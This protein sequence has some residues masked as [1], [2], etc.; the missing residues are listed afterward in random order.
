V[1]TFAI[2]NQKGGAG[3]STMTANLAAA[4]GRQGRRV[5]AVDVDPQ[6]N[7][8]EMLG[9]SPAEADYTLAEL[10]AQDELELEGAV[11]AA[12]LPG[13]DLLL[14]SPLLANVEASLAL[15]KVAPAKY[16][17]KRLT[18]LLEAAAYDVV[19]FDSPP[20]L[21][22][23]TINVLCLA[24]EVVIPIAMS[25]RNAW[26]GAADLVKTIEECREE[27]PELEIR[28]AVRSRSQKS[29]LLY[30]ALEP[31]LARL[32][33]PVL[34]A[35]IPERVAFQNSGAE[36]VPLVAQRPGSP[37]ADAYIDLSLELWRYEAGELAEAA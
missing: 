16:M 7:L 6:F 25:D 27:N 37:G 35:E 21:G 22:A 1:R 23:L 26:K 24:R 19:I 3:K 11:K 17:R 36:G 4:W 18:P 5:L 12:V 28:G 13:V 32:G 8:T 31:E 2:A 29:R 14:G 10:L 20:N 33:L 15:E 30:R 9:S 34:E